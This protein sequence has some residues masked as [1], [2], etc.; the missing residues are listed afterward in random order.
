[1]VPKIFWN[2]LLVAP[3]ILSAAMLASAANAA[4][5]KDAVNATETSV[6]ELTVP[7]SIASDADVAAS[8]SPSTAMVATPVQ[9]AVA[10]TET[11]APGVALTTSAVAP[12][13]IEASTQLAQAVPAAPV[14][15]SAPAEESSL[16]QIMQYSNEGNRTQS[17]VTSISQLSDVQPTDWAFQALQSLV[18]RYGCI[19]GY[20]DGTFR[21]SRAMTR[22]EF[23][24][25][26]NAC[27]DRVN[28]LIAA[29]LADA[30][31]RED[32]ATLQRL[33]EEFAAELATL[34]GRMDGLEARTA[35]LEA[36]QF[37]TT[38][39][40]V[41]R[42]VFSLADAFGSSGGGNSYFTGDTNAVF[43]S[44]VRLSFDTSFFGTDRLRARLQWGNIGDNGGNAA[45]SDSGSSGG[46][47]F[48][49]P[50][51]NG[52]AG[53]DRAISPLFAE[54]QRFNYAGNTNG[55]VVLNRLEY[56]FAVGAA[57]VFVE[58][59]GGEI[60]D[61]IPPLSPFADRE[62]GAISRFGA[63][64]PIYDLVPGLAIGAGLNYNFG[65]NFELGGGYLSG[66]GADPSSDSG[67]FNGDY[68]AFGQLTFGRASGPLSLALTYANSFRGALTINAYGVTGQFK[69]TPQIAIGGWGSYYDSDS[70]NSGGGDSKFWSY[71]GTLS[72]S[73]LAIE[74]S[75]L[76]FVV[77][78]PPRRTELSFNDIR[79]NAGTENA[80]LHVEGFYRVPLTD[81]ISITPGVIWVLDPGNNNSNDDFV[82]GAVR[83][84]FSF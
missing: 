39:R 18:E 52:F 70:V 12:A 82:I 47:A 81:N 58:A 80:S 56:R 57:T 66:E 76:G 36:N 5:V 22:Y 55:N 50:S 59:R 28:E 68:V 14:A 74:G 11:S 54:Q 6:A 26:M 21:G 38:T 23:A 72:I 29:G 67:L 34:R 51:P 79:S 7:T 32:L 10:P 24:A 73:D 4:D 84:S 25:G 48:R 61:I 43:Q 33:Q 35:E 78:V 17:Q 31:T 64:S 75:L 8:P 16:Q 42:T 19:A 27:L 37:S 83:T 44:R 53:R 71:A 30:V 13:A 69:I 1:M 45:F 49:D 3:V 62:Q 46:V 20:P 65:N 15:Q 40:L 60:N 41:G 77:G 63:Y 9:V 2:S